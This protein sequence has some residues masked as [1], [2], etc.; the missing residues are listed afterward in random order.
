MESKRNKI[1]L[2]TGG[3]RGLG[4]DIALSLAQKGLDVVLTYNSKKEE[5]E[6]V[7]KEIEKLGQKAA[8]IQLNV[9][10]VSS[11]D[12]F[13]Q[14][15]ASALKSTFDAEKIDFLINNA[16]V[17]LHESLLTT[18]TAQFDDLINKHRIYLQR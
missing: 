4:K 15:V 12:L 18:T 8:A 11:F 10:D 16:G 6:A 7:V 9:A 5:A 3:S 17:G 14:N 13:F 2:V 1:T